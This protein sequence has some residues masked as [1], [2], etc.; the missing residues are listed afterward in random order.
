MNLHSAP[1]VYTIIVNWNGKADTLACL[2]SLSKIDYRNMRILVVDNGSHDGSADAIQT[3]FPQLEFRQNHRNFGFVGGNNAGMKHAMSVGADYVLLLN[4]DTLVSQDFL[5]RLVDVAEK[6]YQVGALGPTIYYH[7]TPEVIWSAGGEIDWRNGSTKMTGIG[8]VDSG[9]FGTEPR[10]VDFITGCAMLVKTDI[11]KKVRLL[12]DSFFMYYEEV[13]WCVR[14]QRAGYA[15]NHV[16][17]AKIWHKINPEAREASASV[18]YYMT[19]NRLIFLKKTRAN[20]RAWGVTLFGDYLR[21][22]VSWSIRPQWR[23][24]ALQRKAMIAAICD[25]FLGKSGA[26]GN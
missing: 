15:I 1:L 7:E 12:D 21:T 10:E 26:W 19:R 17:T 5:T 3:Q 16:P 9:Q 25:F 11:L 13:E 23:N 6:D 14:F 18:H 20:W 4:N 2:D 22:L 24:K 8:E